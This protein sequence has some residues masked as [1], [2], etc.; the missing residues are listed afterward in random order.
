MK[1]RSRYTICIGF[2]FAI[3]CLG[4]AGIEKLNNDVKAALQET[5][6]AFLEKINS[7]EQESAEAASGAVEG[8]Q[9]DRIS[10]SGD[11]EHQNNFY[12]HTVRWPG[13]SLSLIAKWYTGSYKN[14]KKLARANPRLNPNVIKTGQVI[15]IPAAMLR[16][17]EPLPQKLA[18]RYTPDYFAHVVKHNGEKIKDIADWYTG[19]AANWKVLVKANPNLDA[20][21]LV[22]GNEIF[23]PHEMLKTRKPV[24]PPKPAPS[25]AKSRPKPA[26][27]EPES[28][29]AAEEEIELFGPKKFPGS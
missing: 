19:D 12:Q 23:I 24:P 15:S 22:A 11:A 13:E 28:T 20:N 10:N 25:T 6:K 26:V 16:T 2:I 1:M 17:R 5:R 4:C 21:K 8:E 7:G 9:S 27:A 3:T 29:P 18:A 14:W